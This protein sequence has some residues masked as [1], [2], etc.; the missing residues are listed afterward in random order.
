MEPLTGYAFLR[1]QTR[2]RLLETFDFASIIETKINSQTE[3]T[4]NVYVLPM[5][6]YYSDGQGKIEK[7]HLFIESFK[8]HKLGLALNRFVRST[9]KDVTK[10]DL[11]ITKWKEPDGVFVYTIAFA[12]VDKEL[13]LSLLDIEAATHF[14]GHPLL[15]AVH[16]HLLWREA[17]YQELYKLLER[18]TNF[19]HIQLDI[20]YS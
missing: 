4:R 11:I 16:E 2:I 19:D 7:T 15:K 5:F 18:P 6:V 10:H 17:K 14:L 9:E 3:T 13:P 1:G 20:T 12:E 8:A